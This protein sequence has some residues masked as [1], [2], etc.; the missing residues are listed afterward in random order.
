LFIANPSPEM[1]GAAMHYLTII[2]WFLPFLV[3]IFIYRCSLQGLDKGMVP[4]LT[5]FVELFVRYL[6][7]TFF[8]QRFGYTAVCLADPITWVATAIPLIAAYYHWK[9]RIAKQMEAA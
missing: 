1:V 2:C 3:W 8:A 4:M 6:V 7:I 5:G 9:H